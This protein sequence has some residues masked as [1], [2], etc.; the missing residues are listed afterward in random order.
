MGK[1]QYFTSRIY[2][3]FELRRGTEGLFVI[4]SRQ[5][6][7]TEGLLKTPARSP[8]PPAQYNTLKGQAFF[9]F[10]IVPYCFL[11]LNNELFKRCRCVPKRMSSK[12]RKTHL[13]K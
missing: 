7:L 11:F 6:S 8:S 12:W 2:R 5:E 10:E 3:P 1:D 4:L 13:M 9:L